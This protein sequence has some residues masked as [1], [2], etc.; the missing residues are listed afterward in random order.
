MCTSRAP[1]PCGWLSRTQFLLDAGAHLSALVHDLACFEKLV[2]GRCI[3]A[4]AA[5]AHAPRPALITSRLYVHHGCALPCH[6]VAHTCCHEKGASVGPG[7]PRPGSGSSV[8]SKDAAYHHPAKPPPFLSPSAAAR[9]QGLERSSRLG[10]Q[11]WSLSLLSLCLPSMCICHH[12]A[13]CAHHP[14][15]GLHWWWLQPR[16]PSVLAR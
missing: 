11:P 2:S 9:W 15:P 5:A 6:D 8:L 12:G 14:A 7:L 16:F 4:G 10:T 3:V 1:L 13:G